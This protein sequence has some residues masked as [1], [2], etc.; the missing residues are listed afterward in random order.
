VYK[1]QPD[2]LVQKVLLVL[3][4]R[5]VSQVLPLHKVRQ[6]QLVLLVQLDLPVLRAQ[7]QQVHPDLQV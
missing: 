1:E 5:K 3:L 2:L 7:E 6:V 4:V